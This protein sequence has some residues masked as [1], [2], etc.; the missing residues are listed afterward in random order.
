[1]EK[2][3]IEMF[4]GIGGFRLGLERNGWK[5]VWAN[6][7]DKYA[8]QIYRKNFGSG[9]LVEGDIRAIDA[10]SI[11]DHTLL[12]AGFPC[13]SFSYAGRRQGFEDAR[14]TLFF[15]IARVASA[16]RPPLLLLE[17]VK[18]LLSNDGGRTFAKICETLNDLGYVVDFRVLNSKYYGVP[19]NRERVFII[20]VHIK[21]FADGASGRSVLSEIIIKSFLLE[22]LLKLLEEPKKQHETRLKEWGL[23]YLVWELINGLPKKLQFLK[24][25]SELERVT[26][27]L[28]SCL[29][30][31]SKLFPRNE[32]DVDCIGIG[33]E[34]ATE[35]TSTQT[36]TSRFM[37][38][39]DV[40]YSIIEWLQK[41]CLDES[42]SQKS[43]ST[44]STLTRQIIEKRTFTSVEIEAIISGFIFKD[45][46]FWESWLRGE[47]CRLIKIR[48]SMKFEGRR[49]T[50]KFS[51]TYSF[52][53][54]ALS[55]VSTA[56]KEGQP[57]GHLGGTGSRQVFPIGIRPE[58][59][60]EDDKQ[61]RRNRLETASCLRGGAKQRYDA[62]TCV[63]M[64]SHTKANIKRRCQSRSDSWALDETSSKMGL[65]EVGNIFSSKAA[66]GR[67]Y[68][69]KG[70]SPSLRGFSFGWSKPK[71]L[72]EARIRRLTPIECE[73]LQGFPDGWTEGISET[74]RYK[75]VGNAV[76]VNVVEFLGKRLFASAGAQE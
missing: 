65:V 34:T 2:T 48:E 9:E 6:D 5:C 22:R 12:T 19:Q 4:A 76:T 51:K 41:E 36:D 55:M 56:R 52:R 62:E 21:C 72:E 13:Q 32:Q 25:R 70:L 23:D 49:A 20:G 57:T 43:A 39:T 73:R 18:G 54:H 33:E 61:E 69:P 35:N 50:D 64:L 75:L 11:P 30:V 14:G 24:N 42:S 28:Q 26:W 67:V 74:Q 16:K 66:D 60:R 7:I 46:K 38:E 71:I 58:A 59:H 44:T 68:N 31:Q 17:N 37:T 40:D 45:W 10:F 53:V 3:F 8:C 27:R 1:V 29:G 15:D 63:V 47:L